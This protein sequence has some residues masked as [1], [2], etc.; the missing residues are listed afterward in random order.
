VRKQ[1]YAFSFGERVKGASSVSVPIQ[2]YVCPVAL[3]IMGPDNRFSLDK[4]KEIL[5]VMKER[6]I[7]ISKK[8]GG[9][10]NKS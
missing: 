3:S 1:G 7:R 4:M 2:D 5:P 10:I 8:L 6:A 9:G